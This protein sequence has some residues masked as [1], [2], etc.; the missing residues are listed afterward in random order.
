VGKLDYVFVTHGDMDHYSGI[1]ELLKRQE[2]GVKIEHLVFPQNLCRDEALCKLANQAKS[3]GCKTVIIKEGE[4][5]SEGELHITCIQPGQ[6]DGFVG[7]EGSLVLDV[8]IGNF[9]MLCTGD[10]EA[11]AE[12]WLTT[13]VKGKEYDVLKV[14]HHGSKNSSSEKF[15]QTIKPEIALVSSGEDNRYGHPHKETIERLKK[16]GC[17][18][19]QTKEN[20]A[21]TLR[22]DGNSLT[23]SLFP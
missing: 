14:A 1:E 20:G 16:I 9:S 18:I 2:M 7:N 6:K 4:S 10:V 8:S 5:V 13:K 23:I 11:D 21:I 17:R 22:S 3:V 12:E 15:L 19:Y